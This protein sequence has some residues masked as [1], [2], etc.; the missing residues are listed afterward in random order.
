LRANLA[1]TDVENDEEIE[2]DFTTGKIT[3]LKTG[4]QISGEPFSSVQ[5]QIYQKGG[6]LKL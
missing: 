6:L 2:V 3:R 4:E 1:N 5:M